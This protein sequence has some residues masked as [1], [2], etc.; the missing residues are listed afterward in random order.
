MT[1]AQPLERCYR[2]LLASYPR[3]FR[4][5]R[6]Q[7]ILTV[8]MAGAAAGQRW[9]HPAEVADILHRAIPMR[10]RERWTRRI[11]W[12]LRH[13]RL[14]RPVRVIAGV[15]LLALTALLCAYGYWWGLALLPCGVL[16]LLLA[17]RLSGRSYPPR[18]G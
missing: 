17:A 10:L 9:P 5:E 1:R 14:M 8:L 3:S 13:A 15:W 12:E 11:A 2:R 7:E 4:E 6:E 18:R 16:H